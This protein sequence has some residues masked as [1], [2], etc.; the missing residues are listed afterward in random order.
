MIYFTGDTHGDSERL[1]KK[2]LKKLKKGDTLIIC[3]DFGF[4]WDDSAEEKKLLAKLEKRPYS[5]CFIDGTHEN[6]GLLASYPVVDFGG[7]KARR[8]TKNIHHLM[9]G[10]IY[11]IEDKT[12]FTLGGG[13]N[14]ELDFIEDEE[15][16]GR[17]EVPTKQEMLNG[18]EKLE[19][20]GYKVDYIV[21]HEPPARIRSFLSLST[22][23]NGEITAL[24]AYLDELSVQA[25]FRHWYFACLHKDKR[26]SSSF[27]SLFTEIEEGA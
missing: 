24:G 12:V 25:D 22:S 26:I 19:A 20:N 5:I 9:R 2:S 11:R 3:G 10:E 8:I 27:T 18:V 23:E 13:E 7:G 21:T 4:V 1:S 16:S 14:P 15:I 17:P 6:F